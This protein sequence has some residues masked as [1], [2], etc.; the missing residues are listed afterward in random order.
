MSFERI[1]NVPKR[2]IGDA[3]IKI[4]NEYAKE[5]KTSL[6]NAA[7]KLIENNKIKPKT[8]FGLNLLLNLLQKWRSDLKNKMNNNKIFK[9]FLDKYG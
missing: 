5:N 3:T 8:K 1:I 2:S 4:I 7:R 9:F 6:E